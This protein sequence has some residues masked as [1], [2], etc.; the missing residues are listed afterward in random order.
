MRIN[1]LTGFMKTGRE[2]KKAAG[3]WERKRGR[4]NPEEASGSIA[5]I[6]WQGCWLNFWNYLSRV[7]G[8]PIPDVRVARPSRVIFINIV[9]DYFNGYIRI[10]IIT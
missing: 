5:V 4:G 6:L 3:R 9:L 10:R 2:E 8:P 7:G 1:E